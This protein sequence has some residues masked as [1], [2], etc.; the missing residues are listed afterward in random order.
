[1]ASRRCSP[2]SSPAR[3]ESFGLAAG[4]SQCSSNKRGRESHADLL[5]T[6]GHQAVP[7]DVTGQADR[8]QDFW[9]VAETE[10]SANLLLSAPPGSDN[11]L[12]P[13]LRRR[14]TRPAN[15]GAHRPAVARTAPPDLVRKGFRFCDALRRSAT[16]AVSKAARRNGVSAVLVLI[17]EKATAIARTAPVEL[18]GLPMVRGTVSRPRLT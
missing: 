10:L 7:A 11:W 2:N 9:S 14:E 6:H 5:A 13:C 12:E 8:S 18:D 3:A 15:K 1:M 17:A 4:G 16:P